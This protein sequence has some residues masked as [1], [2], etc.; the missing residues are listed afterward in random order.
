MSSLP[1]T[2]TGVSSPASAKPTSPR[3]GRGS[4]Q[5]RTLLQDKLEEIVVLTAQSTA[6]DGVAIALR[7]KGQFICR[8]SQGFAPEPGVIVEPGHGVCG[9]VI[10]D[11]RVLVCQDLSGDVKSALAAPVI[12]GDEIEGLIAAFSFKPA[13]FSPAHIDLVS[14]IAVDIGNQVASPESIHLVPR[15]PISILNDPKKRDD[16]DEP[17]LSAREKHLDVLDA[18]TGPT[19]PPSPDF[20]TIAETVPLLTDPPAMAHSEFNSASAPFPAY[21]RV[22][23]PAESSSPSAKELLGEYLSKWDILVIFGGILIAMLALSVWIQHRRAQ[24]N[25]PY[26]AQY[27]PDNDTAPEDT[28]PA[29]VTRARAKGGDMSKS[30][31][32]G[33]ALQAQGRTPSS[34]TKPIQVAGG[35]TGS[36]PANDELKPPPVQVAASDISSVPIPEPS[37]VTP[38]LAAPVSGGAVIPAELVRKVEP[39]YPAAA[40]VA[41]RGGVVTLDLRVGTDGKVGGIKVLGGADPFVSAAVNAVKQWRY[42]PAIQNGNKIE[43]SIHVDITFNPTP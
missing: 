37:N 20:S 9:R 24:A 13:A 11:A 7:E 36:V 16:C 40:R 6:A 42:A 23:S 38:R 29:A 30:A 35:K 31:D 27:V 14:R 25:Q 10:I 17:A 39:T 12:V 33:K 8:A 32:K 3:D 4:T 34:S 5:A 28:A 43:S 2:N 22:S 1:I 15:D 19:L 18:V 41:R 26:T 21:D